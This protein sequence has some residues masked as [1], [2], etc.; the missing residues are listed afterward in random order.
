[1]RVSACVLARERVRACAC[2][3]VRVCL[4]V[5][6]CTRAGHTHARQG[7]LAQEVR[8]GERVGLREIWRRV[9]VERHAGKLGEHLR[10]VCE[11]VCVSVCVCVCVCVCLYVYVC[12][13]VCV[14]VQV[15][16]CVCVRACA[17][18]GGPPAPLAVALTT[19]GT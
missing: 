8:R 12:M 18:R 15:R 19:G 2:L 3:R 10:V 11:C 13:C 4:R 14:F 1:M 16:V 9:P 17:C 5:R 7:A 6:A